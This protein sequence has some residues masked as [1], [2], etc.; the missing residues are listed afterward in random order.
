MDIKKFEEIFSTDENLAI[1]DM[2]TRYVGW[3]A[4]KDRLL[5]SFDSISNVNV[6]FKDHSI[7]IHP[8]GNMAWLSVLEDADW[9][10]EE[11]PGK[12]EGIRVTW[13]LEKRND[14]WAVVQGHWSVAQ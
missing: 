2:Q 14:N 9:I 10:E 6:S 7:H 11:Q 12:V 1:F 4:W 5:K 8:L 13:I 3:K